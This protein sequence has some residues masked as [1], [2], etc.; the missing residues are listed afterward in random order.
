VILSV[1]YTTVLVKRLSDGFISLYS[2]DDVKKYDKTSELF[3]DIPKEIARVL[4]Y[5]FTELLSEDFSTLLKYDPLEIPN[6]T[7]VTNNLKGKSFSKIL[8][9][10]DLENE[11]T[12]LEELQK[13]LQKQDLL[14]IQNDNKLKNELPE[15]Q[16]NQDSDEEEEE[17]DSD[18]GW[19]NRLRKRVRFQNN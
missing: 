6:G 7:P 12:F 8:A 18:N 14:D 5:D 11:E 2:M 16:L 10:T 1:R 9:E 15:I 3:Q 4:L 13:D 17:E 19:K